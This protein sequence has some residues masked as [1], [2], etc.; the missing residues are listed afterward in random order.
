MAA[1]TTPTGFDIAS[2]HTAFL[3]E[4]AGVAGETVLYTINDGVVSAP[5]ELLPFD[6]V[7][8]ALVELI[9]IDLPL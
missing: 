2:G 3:P 4:I 9:P 5:I 7:P 6:L 8:S 1:P